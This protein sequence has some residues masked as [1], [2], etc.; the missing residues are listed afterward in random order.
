MGVTAPSHTP[1]RREEWAALLF[2]PG[3]FPDPPEGRTHR[4]LAPEA[5]PVLQAQHAAAGLVTHRALGA[6]GQVP[7]QP[8][9]RHRNL[10]TKQTR[11]RDGPAPH[12]PGAL[13]QRC[14]RM[15]SARTLF[16]TQAEGGRVCKGL[17]HA[18]PLPRVQ[19]DTWGW[20]RT[21]E[22]R[23]HPEP[24]NTGR[25][26]LKPTRRDLSTGQGAAE[27]PRPGC[28]VPAGEEDG[29]AGPAAPSLPRP[30]PR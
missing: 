20:G 24:P 17:P 25:E 19:H 15:N 2:P 1:G 8:L 14:S 16:S 7:L 18:R 23:G 9:V 5:A 30:R 13:G 29:H 3:H 21:R 12:G 22:D 10:Q 11:A 28:R 27:G 6:H 4:D 26:Q